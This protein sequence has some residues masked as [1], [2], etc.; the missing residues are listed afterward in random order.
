MSRECLLCD[1]ICIVRCIHDVPRGDWA[2]SLVLFYCDLVTTWLLFG[3][4]PLLAMLLIAMLALELVLG[5]LGTA[6]SLRRL[7]LARPMSMALLLRIPLVSSTCVSRLLILARI[8]W[9]S[10]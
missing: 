3:Y 4:Y 10:G 2:P 8:R 7:L 5:L 9:C 1:V 6:L